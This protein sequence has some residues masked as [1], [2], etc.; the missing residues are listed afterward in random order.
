MWGILP[1]LLCQILR[2]ARNRL[3][4]FNTLTVLMGQLLYRTIEKRLE[5]LRKKYARI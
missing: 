5:A 2:T 4:T 3:S 1:V